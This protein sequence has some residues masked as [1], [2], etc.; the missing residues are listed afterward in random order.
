MAKNL[1]LTVLCGDYEIVRALR[2]GIVK[3]K[4]IDL[5]FVSSP[6]HRDIHR[7]VAQD[8]GADINEF[9][10]GQYVMAKS[11][12][13]PFTAIPVFLHRRFRHGFIFVN[14]KSGIETAADLVGRTM[15]SRTYTSAADFWMRGL[16]EDD[17]GVPPSAMTWRVQDASEIP[18]KPIKGVKMT[19]I[20]K[21]RN[22]E[23]MFVKGEVDAFM[24]PS[25]PKAILKNDRRVRPLF[26]DHKA[27]EKAYFERTGIFPIMHVTTIR[28]EIV[29]REPW[30]VQSL[31]EA[32]EQS[33]Q[34]LFARI[35]NPRVVPLAWWRA[36]WEEER[37]LL[38]DDPWEFGLS[39]RNQRNYGLL[40][41]YVNRQGLSHCKM[42]LKDL[43]PKQAFDVKA[44]FRIKFRSDGNY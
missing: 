43:F 35:P 7:L 39:D 27:T 8:Q 32:F 28:S 21:G 12:G 44:P 22:I 5:E 14:A 11:I 1:K 10:G 41:D 40:V 19:R 42:K 29:K 18:F 16:L 23:E 37:D 26:P 6:G 25:V 9:N 13:R 36:D 30:V 4:G 15:G 33:K 17:Y 3:P 38:G 31:T 34:H 2:E 24:S 20:P